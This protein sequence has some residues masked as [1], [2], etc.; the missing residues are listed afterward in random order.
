MKA[1]TIPQATSSLVAAGETIA[2]VHWRGLL[3]SK[4][5]ELYHSLFREVD[6]VTQLRVPFACKVLHLNEKLR[7]N[8]DGPDILHAEQH[9]NVSSAKQGVS[10]LSPVKSVSTDRRKRHA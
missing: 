2:E 7:E 3:D 4:A 10:Q 8:P 1:V 6:G 9:P 5:D